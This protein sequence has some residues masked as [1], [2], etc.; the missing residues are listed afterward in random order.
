MS[1][2]NVD[3]IVGNL[4]WAKGPMPGVAVSPVTGGQWRLVGDAKYEIEIVSNVGFEEIPT[5]SKVE[6]IDWPK[7]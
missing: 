2:L 1:T 3:T 5:T 4:D 6:A 7:Q